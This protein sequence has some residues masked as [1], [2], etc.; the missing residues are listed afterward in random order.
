MGTKASQHHFNGTRQGRI[1]RC[2]Q[3]GG[4]KDENKPY[5]EGL[6]ICNVVN[7]VLKL[8]VEESTCN[9][10]N[11]LLFTS[12]NVVASPTTKEKAVVEKPTI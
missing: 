8:T 3:R 2:H 10:F 1:Y 9:S 11:H 7:S 12:R 4:H 5:L 6:S